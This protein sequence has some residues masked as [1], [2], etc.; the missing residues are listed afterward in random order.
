METKL[1]SIF[2]NVEN[3]TS[4]LINRISL[5]KLTHNRLEF[6]MCNIYIYIEIDPIPF[7]DDRASKDRLWARI[8]RWVLVIITLY[9]TR[10][11]GQMSSLMKFFKGHTLEYRCSAKNR[12]R[13]LCL[14]FR[15]LLFASLTR[16]NG[17]F[18][19]TLFVNGFF[20]GNF[21]PLS[22]WLS[23]RYRR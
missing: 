23:R 11:R 19:I 22:T 20:G 6:E 14:K 9:H 3:E 17:P 12:I 2:I 18:L 7:I 10:W 8:D 13:L 4:P 21:D 1:Q 5:M 15:C 16:A